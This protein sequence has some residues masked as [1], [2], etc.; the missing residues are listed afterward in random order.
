MISAFEMTDSR[1]GRISFGVSFAFEVAHAG[2]DGASARLSYASVKFRVEGL[3]RFDE[4]DSYLRQMSRVGIKI[5]LKS[6]SG[7]N[8]LRNVRGLFFLVISRQ[9]NLIQKGASNY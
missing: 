1:F 2:V 8:S 4:S 7:N 3:W 9:V 6:F 5:F